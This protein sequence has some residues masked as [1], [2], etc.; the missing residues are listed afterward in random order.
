MST[1]AFMAREEID[2]V[3]DAV[4][5]ASEHAWK[6]LPFYRFT[7]GGEWSH[8]ATARDASEHATE[9]DAAVDAEAEATPLISTSF[10][11][12]PVTPPPRHTVPP[13]PA[14]G[15]V[16]DALEGTGASRTL[17]ISWGCASRRELFDTV[18]MGADYAAARAVAVIAGE[19]PPSRPEG[20]DVAVAEAVEAATAPELA[21]L[22]DDG[23]QETV[24]ER[25]EHIRYFAYPFELDPAGSSEPPLGA[26][27]PQGYRRPVDPHSR[28]HQD[29]VFV[30]T[31]VRDE[32]LG[33]RAQEL[34][35][36]R[37]PLHAAE[38]ESG[39]SDEPAQRGG[40]LRRML[41]GV[42]GRQRGEGS[43][44]EHRG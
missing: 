5:W 20:L 4:V 29:S 38:E 42:R 18:R 43:R 2:F 15:D 41:R 25:F 10:L 28:T 36:L 30:P 19:A 27:A 31:M 23:T 13:P 39:T 32:A 40:R 16:F 35:G 33:P 3:I 34:S 26:L 37:A 9:A 21:C 6:L 17:A 14:Y 1:P 24:D 12:E 8:A 44:K 11:S 7:L 22:A